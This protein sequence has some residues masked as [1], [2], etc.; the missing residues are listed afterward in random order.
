M[1][2]IAQPVTPV[3]TASPNLL[4]SYVLEARSEFLRVL[5]TPSS[6]VPTLLFPPLFYLLFGVLLNRGSAAAAHYLFAT[7]S[8]FG[9]MAP[10]L[11]GFGVA[12][13]IERERGWLA[14][15]RVAPMPPGGY[16]LAKLAMAMLFGLIVFA[17]L[18]AMAVGLGGG[19][20]GLGQWLELGAITLLGVLPFCALGLMI[21]SKAN[22]NAAPAFVNLI[23]LPMAF[24]SG[25]WM[26]LSMLPKFVSQIAPLWPAY[27]LSQLA[28]MVV[29]QVP[30]AGIV[31]HL[32]WLAGFSAICFGIARRWLA[33]AG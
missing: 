23:F 26:P 10:S 24:L 21:G 1:N 29:G 9:V 17:V 30:V 16:L 27:H 11:Y 14:L 4:R 8:V 3:R 6:A 28:L 7:Y 20:L 22:A 5:R 15:K 12:V 31:G 19:R 25:L 13:A 18:A 32:L 2:A 33:R